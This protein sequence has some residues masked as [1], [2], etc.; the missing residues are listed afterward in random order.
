[1][2]S[3][4]NHL[5]KACHVCEM[6][7]AHRM[8]KLLYGRY[9]PPTD[10]FTDIAVDLMGQLPTS[11][12]YEYVMVIVDRSSRYFEAIPL[13]TSSAEEVI[14]GLMEGFIQSFE[15]PERVVSDN[16]QAFRIG[17]Y[18]KFTELMGFRT[19]FLFPYMART[20]SYSE[21]LV[22]QIKRALRTHD[23]QHSWVDKLPLVALNLRAGLQTM[24][25]ISPA[26]VAFALGYQRQFFKYDG[27]METN[28][29]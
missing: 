10:R 21:G 2:T 28:N 27:N 20:N 18:K 3:D 5:A 11:K 26:Q 1:M 8:S 25:K 7:K 17:T 12:G 13:V 22:K 23:H 15:V 14:R 24:A 4:I 19:S 6:N 16:A 29:P 9:V